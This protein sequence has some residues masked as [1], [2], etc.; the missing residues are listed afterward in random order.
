MSVEA[1]K[2]HVSPPI[3]GSLILKQSLCRPSPATACVTQNQYQHFVVTFPLTHKM[4]FP[5]FDAEKSNVLSPHLRNSHRGW[6]EEYLR[7]GA[8]IRR[9]E[10]TGSIAIGSRSF[11][12][13]VKTLLGLGLAQK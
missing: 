2:R 9:D 6:I 4:I 11:V 10:W 8:E 5:I 13:N 7:S 3:E 12:E 1:L